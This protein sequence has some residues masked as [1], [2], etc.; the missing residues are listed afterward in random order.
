MRVNNPQRVLTG[1]DLELVALYANGLTLDEIG[2]A[3][4]LSYHAVKK[5]MASARERVGARNLTHLC[6]LC[7]DYGVI[8]A[9]GTGYKPVTD[10]RVVG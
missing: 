6:V 4:F 8:A 9:N 7:L 2:Q 5:A 3:K 10:E 1:R